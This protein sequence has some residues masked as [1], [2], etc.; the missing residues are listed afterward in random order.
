[1]NFF[2]KSSTKNIIL[3]LLGVFLLFII[4]SNILANKEGMES[5]EEE[6]KSSPEITPPTVGKKK[7]S[8]KLEEDEEKN[9][10]VEDDSY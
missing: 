10:S 5:G 3:V 1:M 6:S 2:L 7:T 4:F 9:D 8:A